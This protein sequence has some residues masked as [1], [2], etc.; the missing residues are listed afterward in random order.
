MFLSSP[1]SARRA[2]YFVN[3]RTAWL[4]EGLLGAE[5]GIIW[6]DHREGPFEIRQCSHI[7]SNVDFLEV[8]VWNLEFEH[9]SADGRAIESSHLLVKQP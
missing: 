8:Y 6:K 4:F 1:P 2:G 5:L 7:L 3:G 9:E